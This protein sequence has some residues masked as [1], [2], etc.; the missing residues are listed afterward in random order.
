MKKR[1]LKNL[2]TK[3]ISRNQLSNLYAGTERNGG[4][5][6]KNGSTTTCGDEP[7]DKASIEYVLWLNCIKSVDPKGGTEF[8]AFA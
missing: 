4:V 6:I 7:Q 1:V 5:D 2:D 3:K 8:C